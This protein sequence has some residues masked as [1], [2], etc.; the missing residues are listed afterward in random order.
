MIGVLAEDFFLDFVPLGL[1]RLVVGIVS[2][3]IQVV[4]YFYFVI[5]TDIMRDFILLLNQVQ[6][7]SDSR[8]ILE[9]VLA[10]DE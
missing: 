10:N 7:F 9:P 2:E 3:E 8:I 4:F 5:Q 6:F 1:F